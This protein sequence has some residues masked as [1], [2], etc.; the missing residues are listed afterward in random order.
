MDRL[1][2]MIRRIVEFRDARD[3]EQFHT[4]KNLAIKLSVEAAELLE[5]F[6]WRKDDEMEEVV[7]AKRERLREEL[8]DVLIISLLLAHDL[9]MDVYDLVMEKLRVDEQKYPVEKFKGRCEK[10]S[11][12]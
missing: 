11:E 1:E 3:W 9:G 6:V 2:E 10:Y 5:L 4:P 7:E 12:L 8:G